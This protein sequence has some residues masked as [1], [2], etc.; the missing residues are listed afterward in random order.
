MVPCV[1]RTAHASVFSTWDIR[2]VHVGM[3]SGVS[4]VIL[5]YCSL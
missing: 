5:A 3:E 2:Y 4:L 1:R